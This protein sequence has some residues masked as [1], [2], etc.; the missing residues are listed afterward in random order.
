MIPFQEKGVKTTA[1]GSG[2]MYRLTN[3]TL[4][5]AINIFVVVAIL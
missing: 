5:W 2:P 1:H 3:Q 4:I